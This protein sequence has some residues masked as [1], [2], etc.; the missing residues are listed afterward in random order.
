MA[1]TSQRS[2]RLLV[3]NTLLL[4]AIL[5]G[6][7]ATAHSPTIDEVGHLPAGL[8]H[9][10]LGRFEMYRVNPPLVRMVAT[11]PVVLARPE[12]DWSLLLEDKYTKQAEFIVGKAFI[13]ANGER[14]FFFCNRSPS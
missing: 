12:M 7:A 2:G 10:Q 6:W 5:L 13:R 14:S 11:L 1:L 3:F 9:W 4:H 8:S